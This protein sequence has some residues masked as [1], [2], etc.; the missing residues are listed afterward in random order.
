MFGDQL[1]GLETS[2]IGW[3][4]VDWVERILPNT[5]FV[6]K[7]TKLFWFFFIWLTDIEISVKTV[8]GDRLN[9]LKTS[10]L[11]AKGPPRNKIEKNRL[12]FLIFLIWATFNDHWDWKCKSLINGLTNYLLTYL[13]TVV[14]SR[15][16]CVSKKVSALWLFV[17]TLQPN[18]KG[19]VS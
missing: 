14:G 19:K 1:N 2:W 12:G 13:R 5:N 11:G 8:F 7:W 15:D 17:S 10:R 18:R 6:N 3:R 16:T 4:P 9:G